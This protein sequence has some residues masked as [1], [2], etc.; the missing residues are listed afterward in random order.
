MKTIDYANLPIQS[1]TNSEVEQTQ[2]AEDI[3]RADIHKEH[4]TKKRGKRTL[5]HGQERLTERRE[6]RVRRTLGGGIR[7]KIS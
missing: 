5:S 4:G 6:N 2:A 7:Q 1:N 3:I